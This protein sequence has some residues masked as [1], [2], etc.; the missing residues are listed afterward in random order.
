MSSLHALV[1][2]SRLYSNNQIK[3]TLCSSWHSPCINIAWSTF[4]ATDDLFCFSCNFGSFSMNILLE[5]LV[6][7][8]AYQTKLKW[9]GF[10]F[11]LPLEIYFGIFTLHK[12]CAKKKLSFGSCNQCIN[13]SATLVGEI[14]EISNQTLTINNCR[15][16]I[17]DIGSV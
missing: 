4:R 11:Y 12:H 3:Y 5:Y 10:N 1:P 16:I 7:I 2:A 15:M 14:S 17:R 6:K 8:A 13:L 9:W